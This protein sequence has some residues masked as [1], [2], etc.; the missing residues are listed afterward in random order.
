[1]RICFEDARRINKAFWW[2]AAVMLLL[3][4]CRTS[5]AATLPYVD[6][7]ER[8]P[9]PE[10][11]AVDEVPLRIAVA[12]VLSPQ[13][14]IESY[15]GLTDYISHVLNR[16]VEL[17]QRRT[18]AE[19]NDLVA[20]QQVVLAFVCTSAYLAGSAAGT[21]ELLAAPIING[22][23]V[24][25]SDLLVPVESTAQSMA[26]LRGK[27][28]AFTDPMSL[29]GRI[30]PTYLVRLLGE[31]P[32]EFFHSTFFT[33]S[34]DQAIE[35]VAAGVAG[36]A[37]VDSLVLAHVLRRNPNLYQKIKVIHRSP[38]FAI[39]P[40]VIPTTLPPDQKAQLE[41]IFMGM[42][43]TGAGRQ[44]L[45]HFG[46]ERFVAIEDSAYAEARLLVAEVGELP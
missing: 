7:T 20:S 15:Q 28:F 25:Y 4:A 39:P 8:M 26:D 12:A 45:A 37:A 21:M 41:Q 46:V 38:P 33:Y 32:D 14:T 34:H 3:A 22:Q 11:I 9:L 18:Y 16:P 19:V 1:M 6:L 27:D 2:L 31:D 29:S 5:Q 40:V 17:V 44:V 36:G 35:A 23:T 30:Y 10:V 24:Y 43:R 13:G 42:H